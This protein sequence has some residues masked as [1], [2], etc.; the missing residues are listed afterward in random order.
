LEEQGGSW[1]SSSLQE[2]CGIQRWSVRK[3]EMLILYNALDLSD[4]LQLAIVPMSSISNQEGVRAEI[5]KL[6]S[7]HVEQR[8]STR[9][10]EDALACWTSLRQICLRLL[11]MFASCETTALLVILLVDGVQRHREAHCIVSWLF[12]LLSH[13]RLQCE[14]AD[15]HR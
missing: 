8:A 9:A 10:S 11:P 13:V 3:T 15:T 2:M 1:R 12:L 5:I 6:R 4:T 14:G 7:T